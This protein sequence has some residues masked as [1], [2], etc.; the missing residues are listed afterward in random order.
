MIFE[1]QP[2][3]VIEQGVARVGGDGGDAVKLEQFEEITRETCDGFFGGEFGEFKCDG[4]V[5]ESGARTL[6]RVEESGEC[7]SGLGG[8]DLGDDDA[9][10]FWQ[11]GAWTAEPALGG[12]AKL[13][14][15]GPRRAAVGGGPC[16]GEIR[17]FPRSEFA[18]S[19]LIGI[20][21]DGA[22]LGAESGVE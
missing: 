2:C 12:S 22:C 1:T 13:G 21:S 14:G 17:M 4:V 19:F 8:K 3:P 11:G 9:A 5:K 16:G 15:E 10:I 7:A 20:E 6:G 18:P